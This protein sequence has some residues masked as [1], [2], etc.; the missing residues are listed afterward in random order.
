[1]AHHG[2]LCSSIPVPVWLSIIDDSP[3]LLLF[4]VPKFNISRSPILLQ[5]MCLGR[6]GYGD[7][8][9]RDDPGKCD[10]SSVATFPIGNLLYLLHDGTVF[11]EILALEFGNY[12]GAKY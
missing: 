10:L 5:A 1:M 8:T 4:L 11:V 3:H 2:L 6:A 7:Q 12:S 9:L